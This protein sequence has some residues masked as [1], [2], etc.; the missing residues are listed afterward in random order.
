MTEVPDPAKPPDPAKRRRLIIRLIYISVLL[1]VTLLLMLPE[2]NVENH[3]RV[4]AVID[5][6]NEVDPFSGSK[7]FWDHYTPWGN[8]F[9]GSGPLSCYSSHVLAHGW[10]GFLIPFIAFCI[11]YCVIEGLVFPKG[12]KELFSLLGALALS[13]LVAWPLRWSLLMLTY[14]FGDVMGL[15]GWV[16][17]LVVVSAEM[18][19]HA[20]HV[21]AEAMEAWNLG[22]EITKPG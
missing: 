12:G 5:A 10:L 1:V 6:L 14:A 22:K 3:A 17:G 18:V 15:M 9:L 7:F 21:R 11:M 16:N 19:L 2:D 8:C 20:R 4:Q 13:G